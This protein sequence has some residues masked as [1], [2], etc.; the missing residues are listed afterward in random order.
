MPNSDQR[1]IDTVQVAAAATAAVQQKIHAARGFLDEFRGSSNAL[2]VLMEP[3]NL[4]LSLIAAREQ[5]DDAIAIMDAAKWP[6]DADYNQ[7]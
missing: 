5:L 4:R 3:R 6:T 1:I 2:A 7:S